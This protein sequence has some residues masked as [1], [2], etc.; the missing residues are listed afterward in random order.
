MCVT[1]K[2]NY[3]FLI[4]TN[5]SLKRLKENGEVARF[6]VRFRECTVN[7]TDTFVAKIYV[8]TFRFY[9]YSTYSKIVVSSGKEDEREA[10]GLGG[11]RVEGI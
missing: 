1:L 8:P 9:S 4:L 2:L 11:Y 5:S 3:I 6:E 10:K 7:N